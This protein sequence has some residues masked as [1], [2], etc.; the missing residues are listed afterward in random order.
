M[1][2]GHLWMNFIQIYFFSLFIFQ[3]SFIFA[4][5]FY[6]IMKTDM[7]RIS[8]YIQHILCLL[9]MII[10]D[11]AYCTAIE[12]SKSINIGMRQGLSNEFV[13]DMVMDKRGFLWVGTES[14]LNRI[15]GR[16]CTIFKTSNSD[17]S[18]D[19][20]MGLY[21]EESNDRI[22]IH[23]KN[24]MVDVLDCQTLHFNL[25]STTQGMLKESVADINSA[26]DGGIWI[27][28]YHGD[29]QHYDTKKHTFTTFRKSL[30][31]KNTHGTRCIQDDGHGHIYI[32][33]RSDGMYVYNLISGKVRYFENNPKIPQS[34]PGNNVRTICIDHNNNVW[35]GTNMGLVL[36]DEPTGKC[37][38]FQ[39]QV[40]NVTSIVS[41]NIH[42][43]IEMSD[44]TLWVLSDVGGISVLDL[45]KYKQPFI[46]TLSF[47]Q[48][49][50][51][52]SG[53]SSNN[54]RRII[55]DVFG[56]IWIGNFSSG[57]D[58]IP[59]QSSYFH[60]L[61]NMGIP[62][63]NTF[64]IYCDHQG[65]LWIGQDNIIN[66]YR[67]GKIVG[68]WN[69]SSNLLNASATVYNFIQDHKGNLWFGTND[70]GVLVF[71]PYT[72]QFVQHFC[73]QGLDVHALYESP[74]GT[75]WIG[76][77]DGLYT[78]R[79]GVECKETAMNHKMG[80]TATCIFSIVEDEL[81]QIWIAT[82]AKGVFVFDKQRK[83]IIRMD[84]RNTLKS[85]SA[86]QIFKDS[87]GSIWIATF[88]GLAYVANP[89][90]LEAIKIYDEKQ[91]LKDSHIRAICQD[92]KG[93]IWVSMF[94][95]IACFDIQ[96]HHFYNYD[97]QNG[98]PVGNFV[99]AGAATTHDGA[100]YFSSSSGICYFNPLL[101]TEQKVV[102]DV[103]IIG[104]ERVGRQADQSLKTI[105]SPNADGSI[106]LNHDDNTF[107]ISFTTQNFAED[108]NVEYS[109]IM[110]GLDEQWFDTESDNDVIFRNLKPGK[111]TFI[112]RAK[113]KNQDWDEASS[114]ELKIVV[115]PPFWLTWWAKL[116]Y[117]LFI[118][119]IIIYFL[120]S[121]KKELLLR[122]SLAQ[123]KWESQQKQKVNEERL[124][125][126]TNITHELR[127]PL[128]LI[129]GPLED[130]KEDRRLPSVVT[131]KIGS[132]YDSA[133]RLLNLINDI[134]EFRKTETQNRKLS[135]ARAD[136]G[137]IIQEIGTRY[138]ELNHNPKLDI[139]IQKDIPKIYFDSEVIT[140]VV[141]N[142]MSNAIKY[143][144]FGSVILK[145]NNATSEFVA[146]SVKDTGYGINK[147]ALPHICDRYYQENSKHQASGTGIGLALVK[148]LA[149]LHEADLI[150]DSQ[151]GIGSTFSFILKKDNT[152][153]KALHKDDDDEIDLIHAPF[154]EDL[155]EDDDEKCKDN[156]RPLLLIIED[157]S[158]IRQYIE[159]S[160]CADYRILQACNGKEGLN[161]AMKQIPDL[162]VSD[163]MMPE[164]D[165][166]EMTKILKEDI[167]TSH[168]PII[169]L[170]AKTSIAD[171]QE[172][173]DSG[174]DSYL[175]K[176]FSAKL[177]QSRIRNIL[178]CRRKLAE[179]IVQHSFSI[180]PSHDNKNN[181][182]SVNDKISLEDNNVINDNEHKKGEKAS[183]IDTPIA[184][185]S[186]LDLKF[187]EKLNS[188]IEKHLSTDDLDI[189]FMTDKMAMSHSTFYRKVKALT[190]LSAN[191]YIKKAK[192]RQSMML[193]KTK[194][195]SISEVAMLTGFNNLGNF[196][197]SFKREFGMTPSDV[198][199]QK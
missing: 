195:Y 35:I 114:A 178:F 136:L 170:T 98:I 186:K 81:G 144:P 34:F 62:I 9:C 60:T 25:F 153:P 41:G 182:G 32:G 121:Y 67:D 122:N 21:Y 193:L 176:P 82:L 109:Y 188:I 36:F 154:T 146:I 72:H 162:I 120:R 110:K 92:R 78:I 185:L 14:G 56:N 50:K 191:E 33:L 131:K 22:W 107:K 166:I 85:N 187:I 20:I 91:G 30:F 100:L 59:K 111:Y 90:H 113:L 143:T 47:R 117:F 177:L 164:M 55:E 167:R 65:D 137:Y 140:T 128:T 88:K 1:V 42:H 142:L 45:N 141:N 58:F 183:E 197:E 68:S 151:K 104:C 192:L 156:N 44:H 158:D 84:E 160:L 15:A 175:M 165:G 23:F 57:V 51:D 172:G 125:F 173:Y 7:L 26:A 147:E 194:D 145:L 86:N 29:I 53:L 12:M 103:E 132:I 8:Y 27:A 163:I 43:V 129:L 73:I 126:F 157:N 38:I 139:E 123:T 130:L 95:G 96:K 169:L 105:I 49:T 66:K 138:K 18:A 31:P 118:L 3:K 87:N 89:A 4:D 52:N 149:Q 97:F 134:L 106:R 40:G 13:N 61:S 179:Y 75:M 148:S 28:Y 184:E 48:I 37:R 102:S 80:S 11:I 70:N 5:K 124:R 71:N 155:K 69:F 101:L 74:D 99:E 190:G 108:G 116:G 119:G 198:K 199:K 189:A 93:N 135:V 24:G 77:E 168:I 6:T 174:A 54:S 83:L 115:T 64:G 152:Y 180:V 16:K 79:N 10:A 39:P 159:E 46:E 94:S 17:I 150:V 171:Q 63:T 112:I 181:N 19:E 133:E 196:R 161:I 76:S 127:T 2:I